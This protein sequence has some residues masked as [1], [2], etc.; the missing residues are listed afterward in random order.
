MQRATSRNALTRRDTTIMCSLVG[1][2]N[3]HKPS[4]TVQSRLV[5]LARALSDQNLRLETKPNASRMTGISALA[6]GLL[7]IPLGCSSRSDGDVKDTAGTNV[8][9]SE[10]AGV[11]PSSA[12]PNSDE[13][14]PA[15][16]PAEDSDFD[17]A[18]AQLAA[19]QID[20]AARH[21]RDHL[22]SH[23]GDI[24]GL[25][26]AGE[27]E[28][29][30]G[31][32]QDAVKLLDEIPRDHPEAGLA[33]LGQSADWLLA[34]QAW[35]EAER[36]YEAILEKV[37]N[38]NMAHRRL[39]YLM[40]RQGRRQEASSH[41]RQLCRAGD[42]T[43]AE[44]HT[45]INE[46]EAV[47]DEARDADSSVS[48]YAPIGPAA[49]AR[50]LFAAN[51]FKPALDRLRIP[52]KQGQ[53]PPFG[54]A[55]FGRLAMEVEDQD[56][57]ALW[58]S[59]VSDEQKQFGDFWVA[60]G[61]W[62]LRDGSDIE[63]A[64][65]VFSE[66][67]VRNPTDWIAMTRLENCLD[68]LGE[69]KQK[70]A[71]R[72]RA[73]LLQRSIRLHHSIVGQSN[74]PLREIAELANLLDTLHRPVEAVM[75]RAMGVSYQGGSPQA[76][77][78]LNAQRQELIAQ[79]PV[80]MKPVDA[81][82]GLD[83]TRFPI[84]SDTMEMLKS[85]EP[86]IGSG[87]AREFPEAIGPALPNVA[88]AVGIDFQYYNASEPKLADTQIYEQFGGGAVALDY[89]LD[90]RVDLY[91]NQ[92]GDDPK[93]PTRGKSNV[94]YRNLVS[95]FGK[96]RLAEV[97]DDGYGQG[98][99]S[100]DWNQDGFPDLVIANFGI[101]TLMINNGDGTFRPNLAGGDWQSP[102]WTTS[103]AMADVTGDA[104]PDLV[105]VNYSDD[106]T[107]HDVSPRGANGR[108]I[109]SKGPV[110][111]RGA[112]DRV[113]IQQADGSMNAVTL[114]AGQEKRFGH[115]LGIVVTDIDGI[116]GNEIFVANDTDANQLW[117][118]DQQGAESGVRW[119]DLAGIRG[120]AYSARG[121]SG[122]SMGIATADFDRN[123]M[124]DF[125][126][127]NFFNEPVHLFLQ[128][129][130]HI[131]SDS[132]IKSDLYRPSLGVLGFGTQ[133]LDYDNNGTVDLAVVNGH[134]D[135]L[136][137][138]ESPHKMRPQLFAGELDRFVLMEMDRSGGYWNRPAIG[139][140]LLRLDWNRDGKMDLL[141]THHDVPAALLENHTPSKYHWLQIRLV[142][143]SSE[144]D[145]IGAR[146][147]VAATVN[148]RGQQWVMW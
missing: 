36:R 139:R 23:P 142:G 72:S 2:S 18:R 116:T 24:A 147:V 111:Y 44:L 55:F 68:L 148:A 141:A 49:E 117:F 22:L 98:V 35:D 30:R 126:V 100:G 135:D 32:Y 51:E 33:A 128:H 127:T 108:F 109:Q 56:A 146:V 62:M 105:E 16:R 132:V 11:E 14:R 25:F 114:S 80:E 6:V 7:L 86:S 92:G 82:A 101:N 106:P 70:I 28:A 87:G 17:S 83:R 19:G 95:Q 52:M 58:L 90:G 121:G 110:S 85:L 124:I 129:A 125:H 71:C 78:A 133:A 60:L 5:F 29:A 84:P 45:L 67:M 48:R 131:F 34:A 140:G 120:C 122:A 76:L 97:E 102:L 43:Q 94:L 65:R 99:T 41:V 93:M 130:S 54:Q 47:H 10:V 12:V 9:S 75:W 89:D 46:C 26:L 31:R 53:L 145:A 138:K 144:R 134:I 77:A 81:L 3:S 119:R 123:G 63:G 1:G 50:V 73:I 37:P 136:R 42:V 8:S 61:T 137:Y 57:I 143:T 27:I 20:A 88:D 74:P 13:Q 103:V 112:K 107:I 4:P 15:E 96:A 79:V 118:S 69:S 40:N 104:L 91:F 115:G 66:A 113:F 38:F 64:A 21:I 39:A 59:S